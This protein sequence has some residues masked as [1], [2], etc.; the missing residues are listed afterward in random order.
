[1]VASHAALLAS[2]VKASVDYDCLTFV[3]HADFK[4]R[5]VKY[6]PGRR[7]LYC[8]L[9]Y[10]PANHRLVMADHTTERY[11]PRAGTQIDNDAGQSLIQYLDG[12]ADYIKQ[13]YDQEFF[14]LTAGMDSRVLFSVMIAK[15]MPM[16]VFTMRRGDPSGGS[17]AD[18]EMAKAMCAHFS[19][20]HREVQVD[21]K[22]LGSKSFTPSMQV[23]RAN[24]GHMRGNAVVANAQFS[25]EF[26]PE[27]LK[28]KTSYSRGFGGEIMRGFYHRQGP[29]TAKHFASLYGLMA[30]TAYVQDSFEHFVKCSDFSQTHGIAVNDL[31]YWEHR[32]SGWAA[33]GVAETDIF[34]NTFAGYNSR[35]LYEAFMRESPAEREARAGFIAAIR[36]YCPTLLDWEFA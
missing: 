33:L 3:Q 35:R 28:V 27:L 32:M 6:L 31:Y 5:D 4:A 16:Q 8:D 17:K 34:A 22:R 29:A 7:T 24:T 23:L 19:L 13:H 21:F 20:P 14:G 26:G 18:M 11:W 12:Y 25:D 1:M 36:H 2:A 9:Y 30:G 15:G 10:C